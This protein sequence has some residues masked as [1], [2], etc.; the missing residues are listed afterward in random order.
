[1]ITDSII[2]AIHRAREEHLKSCEA[3]RRREA[4]G[5][6]IAKAREEEP[7][8]QEAR[9][10]VMDNELLEYLDKLKAQVKEGKVL[11]L[12]VGVEDATECGGFAYS[13][14][15]DGDEVSQMRQIALA[16]AMYKMHA[17]RMD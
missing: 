11:S 1:M 13:Q 4:E 17:L 9:Q 12:I 6:A 10:M 14:I 2:N 3:C 16:T 5:E 15:K 8:S 7:P